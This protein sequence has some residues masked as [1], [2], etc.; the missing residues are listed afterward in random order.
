MRLFASFVLALSIALSFV[1]PSLGHAHQARRHHVLR[2]GEG[3]LARRDPGQI[4]IYKRFD[5]ARFTYYAVGLG[6]CGWVNKQSD[7]VRPF[8]ERA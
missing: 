3:D 1:A 4:N 6:A 5:Q 7:F 8:H 2:Q